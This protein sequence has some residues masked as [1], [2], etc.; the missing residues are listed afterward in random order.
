MEAVSNKF[1]WWS[2]ETETEQDPKQ[3]GV[4]FDSKP[5][6]RRASKASNVV[7][8]QDDAV[9]PPSAFRRMSTKLSEFSSTVGDVMNEFKRNDQ[10]AAEGRTVTEDEP[11]VSGQGQ[12]SFGEDSTT[13]D[14]EESA[15]ETS[16][17]E[18]EQ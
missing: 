18:V 7:A 10:A 8:P 15:G 9:Q 1:P 2:A 12:H 17:S 3:P 16:V 11:S 6:N 14:G 4:K 5:V 13:R